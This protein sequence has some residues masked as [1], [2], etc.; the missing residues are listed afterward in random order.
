MEAL[1]AEVAGVGPGVR[2]DE[3]VGGQGVGGVGAVGHFREGRARARQTRL[4]AIS[5]EADSRLATP[6]ALLY[7]YSPGPASEFC[8]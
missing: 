3:Q 5:G 7:L 4:E 8:R 2:V 6:P 1:A